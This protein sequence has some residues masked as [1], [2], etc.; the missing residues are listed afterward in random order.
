MKLIRLNI[1]ALIL[2]VGFSSSLCAEDIKLVTIGEGVSQEMAVK[3]ALV[4]A[5]EQAF[6]VYVSGNT[7]ILDD[8]LIRD[9]IVQIKRGNIKKYN[10][11]N[12]GQLSD[13]AF[14]VTVE[15]I[16]SPDRLLKFV[17]NKGVETE[18]AG[19]TFG[20]N[21]ELQKLNYRNGLKAME[22]LGEIY[23]SIVP[24]IF[25]Y[26]LQ[27]GNPIIYKSDV[28]IPVTIDCVLN[29]NYDTF[30]DMFNS[31]NNSIIES[32]ES[33]PVD[34]DMRDKNADGINNYRVSFSNMPENWIFGFKLYDNIGGTVTPTFNAAVANTVA[35]NAFWPD[36]LIRPYKYS[37][38]N[39]GEKIV[40]GL[41]KFSYV[42]YGEKNVILAKGMRIQKLD[43]E[44]LCSLEGSISGG[45]VLK[46]YVQ[47]IE[48]K[49]SAARARG[50]TG[51]Y[52]FR[53]FDDRMIDWT[54]GFKQQ[55]NHNGIRHKWLD[56]PNK[57]SGVKVCTIYFFLCYK[58]S[59][60]SKVTGIK[61][62]PL[63]DDNEF[64]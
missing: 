41:P 32:I 30:V 54:D 6:G 22:I 45:H 63:A 20:A 15:A 64:E 56:D 21:L 8:E 33:V 42:N 14:S 16:V 58:E 27:L 40:S 7:K 5:I 26:K 25:D 11:L 2:I 37:Y 39:S 62:K 4:S 53:D 18:L 49:F 3:N 44:P 38:R 61:I 57:R 12:Q 60:I 24:Q 28:Y 10:I 36:S 50:F 19:R 23:E 35:K 43:N 52:D 1:I 31:T 9:E 51:V 46:S 47:P 55:D 48:D 59:D 34:G 13:S 29:D 17:Q